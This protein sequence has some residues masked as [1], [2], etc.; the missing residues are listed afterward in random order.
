M[1]IV[2]ASQLSGRELQQ[3]GHNLAAAARHDRQFA[4]H[5]INRSLAAHDEELGDD[6]E[7]DVAVAC[8]HL[9]S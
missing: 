4:H 9:A 8:E 6:D 3:L 2:H 5:A 1:F 7:I